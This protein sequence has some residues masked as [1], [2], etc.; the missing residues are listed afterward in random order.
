MALQTSGAISLANIASEFGGFNPNGSNPISLNEYYGAASG[1]PS[2]GSI[3]FADFYGA[4]SGPVVNRVGSYILGD[5]GDLVLAGADLN[6]TNDDFIDT[7]NAPMCPA[8]VGSQTG[9][10][11]ILPDTTNTYFYK[12]VGMGSFLGGKIFQSVLVF[13]RLDNA[14]LGP[15]ENTRTL[16]QNMGTI[17][18]V[19]EAGN[20]RT[21]QANGYDFLTNSSS[22]GVAS[23][24]LPL[25]DP[26]YIS[27]RPTWSGNNGDPAPFSIALGPG[28]MNLTF[29]PNY[30]IILP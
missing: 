23:I 10:D 17:T 3:D 30:S 19:H 28:A 11:I 18:G 14:P 22:V 13:E 1:I 21:P 26:R 12:F 15:I 5:G 16:G 4:S 2:S 7:I 27:L 29:N 6:L 8:N 25:K 9:A 24:W 20:T